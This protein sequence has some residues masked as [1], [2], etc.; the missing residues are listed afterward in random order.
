MRNGVVPG[1]DGAGT[2][3]AIGKAVTRFRVGDTVCTQYN[4]GHQSGLI[5][6]PAMETGLGSKIDGTLR[7]AGIFDEWTL[8]HMPESLDFRYACTL[9][10]AAV[11]AWNA[12]FGLEGRRLAPGQ[13]VLTQ[14]S[15][16]VSV[17]AIQVSL[18]STVLAVPGKQMPDGM[19]HCISR[20]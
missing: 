4:P 19:V 1:S 17:F 3:L 2:V 7:K 20:S 9:S 8:V 13:T 15:G 11:T 5:T 16:G 14:G 18:K 12:L 10:C 6:L